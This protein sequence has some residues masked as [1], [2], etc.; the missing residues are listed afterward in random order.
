M[1]P[2]NSRVLTLDFSAFYIIVIKLEKQSKRN[3]HFFLSICFSN[4]ICISFCLFSSCFECQI[5]F[6]T[7]LHVHYS[8]IL[9]KIYN[10]IYLLTYRYIC[11]MFLEFIFIG[12][13]FDCTS[14]KNV[15][16]TLHI[17]LFFAPKASE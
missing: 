14:S 15:T 16:I 17:K 10:F 13:S 11:Y 7:K 3:D 6:I 5:N 4:Y 1:R 9:K 12:I 2:P 8:Q